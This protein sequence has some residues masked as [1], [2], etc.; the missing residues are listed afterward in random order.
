MTACLALAAAFGGFLL[1]LAT[2]VVHRMYRRRSPFEP[3]E[4]LMRRSVS[5]W[6]P[7]EAVHVIEHEPVFYDAE[8]EGWL[9]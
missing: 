2:L 4:P 7:G 6:P 1:G 3:L 9:Q 8:A 5:R